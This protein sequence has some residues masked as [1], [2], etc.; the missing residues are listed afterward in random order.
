MALSETLKAISD[1][2]R[3]EILEMLLDGPKAAGEIASRFQLSAATVSHHFN[4]LKAANLVHVRR[5]GTFLYYELNREELEVVQ[6]WLERM[7]V[8]GGGR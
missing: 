7:G 1:P 2:R 5:E 3:R 8:G 6:L 4:Q